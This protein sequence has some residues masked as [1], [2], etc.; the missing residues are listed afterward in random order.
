M[1]K[2]IE[3]VGPNRIGFFKKL[4]ASNELSLAKCLNLEHDVEAGA[5]YAELD[6]TRKKSVIE[7]CK[8]CFSSLMER[9]ENE[10]FR[11]RLL[12]ELDR[13]Y[14]NIYDDF[15]SRILTPGAPYAES[16]Y[17]HQRESL[18]ESAYKLYNLFAFE[19]GLGK[20]IT[21]A[22]VSRIWKIRRT[23]IVCP[24]LVKWN[25]FRDLTDQSK[26]WTFNDMYFSILDPTK[27]RC[28]YAFQERFVIINFENIEKY[29]SYLTKSDV[30]H[31]IV[32]EC[33]NIKNHNTAKYKNV[34][35]LVAAFPQARVSLLTGTPVKNRVNDVFAYFKL[36]HHP[37]GKN[38]TEFMKDYTEVETSKGGRQ[39]IKGARNLDDLHVKM[40]NFMIRHIKAE[41][42]D[43]PD[44]IYMK[45][46]FELD[47]YK[48]EY[49]K[50]IK[51]IA[52]KKNVANLNSNLHTLNIVMT[53]AKIP[54]IIEIANSILDNEEKVIIFSSY[55]EPLSMLEKHF[56]SSCVKI[57]GSVPAHT[58]DTLIQRFI[59]D[60]N[61]TVFLANYIAGGVGINL[62]NACNVITANNPFTP[63][64]IDQA[65]DRAHRIGQT[66]SVNIH[67]PICEKSVDE[68]LTD[69]VAGKARDTNALIDRDHAGAVDYSNIPEMLYKHI[70]ENYKSNA[71]EASTDELPLEQVT[72]KSV[73]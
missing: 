7:F 11:N 68:Y 3:F 38:Y 4:W 23:I 43:L 72:F 16:F 32:D 55:K 28:L 46:R 42:L 59:N 41:C 34:A 5:I 53:K 8:V 56:G 70:L 31:I 14:Q 52:E 9:K 48:E 60:P 25:W 73:N 44:K 45:Y 47:D 30:G 6:I 35:K 63:A 37:L 2:E 19:Q 61:C 51:E 15:Y 66:K 64:E 1:L 57:D 20:T 65:V 62:V 49:E 24:A 67:M 71:V 10:M 27:S 39:K 22:T 12:D 33:H 69:M 13:R 36:T 18:A 26:P 29:M 21:A 58:R 50:V 17:Y 40:S 54:G